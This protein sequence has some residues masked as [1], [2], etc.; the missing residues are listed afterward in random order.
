MRYTRLHAGTAMV[1]GLLLIPAGSQAA[2]QPE[3]AAVP[4]QQQQIIIAQDSDA[5]ETREKLEELLR[6]LPPA[7]GRVLRT[8]PSLLANDGYLSTYPSLAAFIKQHPEIRSAPN[9]FFEHVG[10]TEFWSP[11][12][13]D[14]AEEQAF[15]MWRELF[16]GHG[17]RQHLPDRNPRR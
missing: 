1:L 2:Q 13:P 10:P 9:F 6:K 4:A 8:D 17:H 16:Q 3:R 5:R 12:R 11:S 15:R 7:V 14:T